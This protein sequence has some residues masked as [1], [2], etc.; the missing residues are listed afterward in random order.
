MHNKQAYLIYFR[1][2]CQKLL[3]CCL[4]ELKKNREKVIVGRQFILSDIKDL[5]SIL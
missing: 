4:A 5:L 1:A 3:C 2:Q